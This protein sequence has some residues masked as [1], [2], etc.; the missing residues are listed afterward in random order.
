MWPV[1]SL[2]VLIGLLCSVQPKFLPHFEAESE[3]L[4]NYINFKSN[5]TWKVKRS[6]LYNLRVLCLVKKLS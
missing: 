1:V 3:D 2:T 6:L 4:F 5:S